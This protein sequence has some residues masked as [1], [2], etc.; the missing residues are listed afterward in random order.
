M[1]RWRELE[2][3]YGPASRPN[4]QPLREQMAVSLTEWAQQQA[5]R[6]EREVIVSYPS[7]DAHIGPI[8]GKPRPPAKSA[9]ERVSGEEFL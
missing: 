4:P 7:G 2:S 3:L 8:P 1:P 9:L 5:Q 6:R